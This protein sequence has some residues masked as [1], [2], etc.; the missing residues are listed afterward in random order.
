MDANFERRLKEMTEAVNEL[1]TKAES[2]NS[3][4]EALEEQLRILDDRVNKIN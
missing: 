4:D 3:T 2:S 1:L